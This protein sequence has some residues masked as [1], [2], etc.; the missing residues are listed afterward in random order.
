M[1]IVSLEDSSKIPD[2]ATRESGINEGVLPERILKRS[3]Q[4]IGIEIN[5]LFF[6]E[7]CTESFISSVSVEKVMESFLSVSWLIF[8]PKGEY[9]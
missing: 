5:T 8:E 6:K 2:F 9:R 7:S 3:P 1:A 4:T